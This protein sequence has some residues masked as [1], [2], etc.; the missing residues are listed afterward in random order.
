MSYVAEQV[1]AQEQEQAWR[2]LEI[3][4]AGNVI[5]DAFKRGEP[6]AVEIVQELKQEK[7]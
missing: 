5:R 7:V 3:W 2:E 4:H 6:M 1:V